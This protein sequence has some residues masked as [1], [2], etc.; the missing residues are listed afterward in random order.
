[1]INFAIHD[2]YRIQSLGLD[3]RNAR[4]RLIN[5]TNQSKEY[6]CS[7]L[8][9]R[10]A[11]QTLRSISSDNSK[12][13]IY[14]HTIYFAIKSQ[15]KTLLLLT[16]SIDN[17]KRLSYNTSVLQQY[18]S[19]KYGAFASLNVPG[20]LHLVR[21]LARDF[22]ITWSNFLDRNQ[23]RSCTSAGPIAPRVPRVFLPEIRAITSKRVSRVHRI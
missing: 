12:H 6:I 15:K 23:S 13:S 3:A 5:L 21:S 7:S 20:A 4:K 10:L 14:F 1:V 19:R 2:R 17:V 18:Y 9:S 11:N 16:V 22:V 8:S